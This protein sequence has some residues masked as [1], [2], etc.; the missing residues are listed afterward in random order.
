MTILQF[1]ILR[2]LCY[3]ILNVLIKKQNNEIHTEKQIT[4]VKNTQISKHNYKS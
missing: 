2:M 4:P 1:E 3:T